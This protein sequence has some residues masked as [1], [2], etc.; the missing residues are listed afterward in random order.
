MKIG[1]PCIN[2]SVQCS[3]SKTFRL[4]SYSEARLKE[5]VANNLS[6]LER[7][8]SYNA[9]RGILFF[10]VSSDIVPFA[11][12][13]VCVFGWQGHFRGG[14][15][16]IGARI[17]AH[18]MR[19]SMHP[20]QFTLIN[21]HDEEIYDRSVR[22][23]RYHCEL[24]DLCG[25]DRTAKVQIHVGGVYGDK[26]ASMDRFVRRYA[27]LGD[28]VRRRL[29]IENDDRLYTVSDC[30][31][32]HAR[33]GVPVLLDVFH[34]EINPDGLSLKESFKKT[35]ATWLKRD[36]LP[37][38]DYSSQLKG[39]RPG[40]HAVALDPRRFKKFLADSRPADFDLMLEIK[41]K[42]KSALRAIRIAAGDPRLRAFKKGL[43][44][45]CRASS[46]S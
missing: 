17:R 7:I 36:G 43:T 29:V 45:S 14:L 11:S 39:A 20:D 24:L 33:T 27:R 22:E 13:P 12:H 32:L 26:P 18:R 35:A 6:C 23:L 41:D 15:E 34:R 3:G 4:A 28:A 1:Y 10:R 37:M 5:T 8:I 21:S 16:R 46:M 30:L 2:R 9:E 31:E 40:S 42:E 44:K 38:V 19:I 25:L